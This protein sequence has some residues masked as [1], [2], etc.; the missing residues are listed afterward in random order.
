M[1]IDPFP[2]RLARVLVPLCLLAVLP[3]QATKQ[4]TATKHPFLWRI[5]GKGDKGEETSAV[6]SWLYGTMH[7]GDEKLVALP[8]SVEKVLDSVDAVY[9]ELEMDQM[10]KQQQK[11]M[12]K[13]LLPQGQTLEDR[14]P[15]TTY[16]RLS[17]Y[18]TKVGGSMVAMQRMQVWAVSL[19]LSVMDAMKE[20]M[21]KS[22]DMMLYKDAKSE[23]IEVGGLE[24]LD[25]QLTALADMPEEDHIRMLDQSLAYMEKLAAKGESWLRK[26][27]AVYLTGDE[28]KLVAVSHESMGED[29]VLM[30]RFMKPL[31]TDRNV[32]MAD[33]M[34][35]MM[36]ENPRKSYL[37]AVGALHCPGKDGIV[38]LL[39]RKGYRI[40]RIAAPR[41]EMQTPRPGE[42]EKARRKLERVRR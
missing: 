2:K 22:L 40:T 21:T 31:V 9:C 19:N 7:L 27:Q 30:E 32:R 16:K 23:G 35:K 34:A 26:I 38:E 28:D 10:Q 5:D 37:F 39:G 6:K 14:L 12:L 15:K 29:K 13:M 8:D 36:A 11:L 25:E 20:K 42:P 33:R 3:A 17:D 24:T 4:V 41:K 1:S 18:V